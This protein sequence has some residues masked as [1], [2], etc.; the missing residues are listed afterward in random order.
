MSA[1]LRRAMLWAAGV[2]VVFAL[3]ALAN[4]W[5]QVRPKADQVA[6]LTSQLATANEE[7]ATARP[8]AAEADQLRASLDQAQLRLLTLQALVLV[9]DARVALAQGDVS[10]ARIQAMT[11]DSALGQLQ[12]AAG[13]PRADD[14]SA[15]RERLSLAIDEIGV[16]AFAAQRDLEILANSLSALAKD[17]AK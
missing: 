13:P 3:G 6:D 7:L 5:T 2:V 4:W 1:L 8:K 15:M 11:A 9:N 16:D 14:L 17:L 12:I 10:G